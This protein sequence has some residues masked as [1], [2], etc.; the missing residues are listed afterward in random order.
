MISHRMRQHDRIHGG[1]QSARPSGKYSYSVFAGSDDA[2]SS[3]DTAVRRVGC[4]MGGTAAG[5]G[6]GKGCGGWDFVRLAALFEVV[7]VV[8]LLLLPLLL[9]FCGM[10]EVEVRGRREEEEDE[11]EEDRR[12]EGY[13]G[14]GFRGVGNDGGGGEGRGGEGMGTEGDLVGLVKEGDL[15]GLE[16]GGRGREGREEEERGVGV[17]RGV[18]SSSLVKER[19]MGWF[20]VEMWELVRGGMEGPSGGLGWVYESIWGGIIA[21]V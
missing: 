2:S 1:I 21:F 14:R 10:V 17:G 12:W 18:L 8:L 5:A 13:L 3:P 4:G 6:A 11:E 15:V 9:R 16:V 7:V 19:L 20:R